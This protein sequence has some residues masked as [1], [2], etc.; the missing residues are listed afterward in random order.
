MN[1]ATTHVLIAWS[2]MDIV[3]TLFDLAINLKGETKNTN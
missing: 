1:I 3:N 2:E